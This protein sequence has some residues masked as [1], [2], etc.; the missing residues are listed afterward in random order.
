MNAEIQ[1]LTSSDSYFEDFKPGMMIRHARGKTV[2]ALE[3]VLI[4]NLVMNTAEG[5]FNEHRMAESPFKH[6]ITFGGV[7]ASLI[8][9][10]ASQD[11]AENAL[12]ELGL[13]KI[14]FKTPVLHGDTLYAFTEVLATK[15]STR[16]DAGEVLFRHWGINQNDKIVFEGERRVQVK[17]RS[18]WVKQ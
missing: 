5:H 17:R 14:R 12:A 2:E 4:T 10:I 7:T 9:G 6:R 13:D 15:D 11:T 8:I 3:N 16:P 1:K 18:H